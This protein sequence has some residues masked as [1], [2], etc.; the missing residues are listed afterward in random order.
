[1]ATIIPVCS[2]VQSTAAAGSTKDLAGAPVA[3]AAAAAVTSL[4]GN[5]LP[6]DSFS[7]WETTLQLQHVQNTCRIRAADMQKTCR[8]RAADVQ[9]IR[10]RRAENVKQTCTNRAEYMQQTCRKHPAADMYIV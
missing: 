1:M 8:K 2:S 10:R 9:Q 4:T 3:A 7:A 6:S 5:A